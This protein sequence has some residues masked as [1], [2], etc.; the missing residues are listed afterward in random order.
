MTVE[1]ELCNAEQKAL[2]ATQLGAFPVNLKD[3]RRNVELILTQFGRHGF[4]DEYTVHNFSHCYEMLKMLDWIIPTESK[5]HMSAG[6]WLMITLATYFHDL[7]LLVTRD[8]FEN[9][10]NSGFAAFCNQRLFSDP[11]GAD[12]KEKVDR[13]SDDQRTKFL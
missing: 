3:I 7:G 1:Y 12:Y 10:D 5:C 4:F 2:E 6:D 11:D 13:L 9:R 8:E